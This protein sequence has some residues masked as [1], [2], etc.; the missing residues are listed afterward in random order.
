MI[1]SLGAGLLDHQAFSCGS[2]CW[3]A[4]TMLTD[5]STIYRTR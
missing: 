5:F 1:A 4:Y 2:D 3:Q